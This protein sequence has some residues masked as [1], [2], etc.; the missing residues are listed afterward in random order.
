MKCLIIFAKE[1]RKGKV[2]TRLLDCLTKNNCLKLYKAFL[3]D[4]LGVARIVNCEKKIIAYEG[5]VE[6]VYL[7]KIGRDFSFYKQEGENLGERMYNAFKSAQR[8]GAS[9]IIVIG[10][11][12]PTILPE[13]I[14]EAFDL[15]DN[16]DIVLGPAKD[17]G[18]YLMGLKEPS[19]DLFKNVPW[20]TKGV[21]TQIIAN[22]AFSGKRV[23]EVKEWYD[24]DDRESLLCL[25]AI[26]K[27]DKDIKV[28]RWTKKALRSC[29]NSFWLA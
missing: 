28:A 11:D 17:Q 2:K 19:G 20:S 21:F 5:S 16:N 1:P 13:F 18:F 6:P 12:S 24:V 9:K 27:Q 23:A 29:S 4:T 26:L 8:E 3:R 10:S 14:E 25:S 15:L 22:A 7:R